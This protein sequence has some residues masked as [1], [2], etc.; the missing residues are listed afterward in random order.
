MSL[1][2][3]LPDYGVADPKM[4]AGHVNLPEVEELRARTLALGPNAGAAERGTMLALLGSIERAELLIRRID[5]RAQI[6]ESAGRSRPRFGAQRG[7]AAP[8]R[9]HRLQ[10]G[11]SRITSR[12][13]RE[14]R[15]ERH[16]HL[17]MPL[18]F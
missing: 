2:D 6:G 3:I 17:A 12:I 4:P 8:G 14:I 5:A 9:R 13:G 11:S 16:R 10:P 7:R 1:R 15:T 18:C